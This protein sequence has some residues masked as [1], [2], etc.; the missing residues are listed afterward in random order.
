MRLL[1]GKENQDLGFSFF[2][3]QQKKA[4]GRISVDI[5]ESLTIVGGRQGNGGL[6]DPWKSYFLQC[7]DQLCSSELYNGCV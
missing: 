5:K 6:Q 4:P 1:L 3:R 7:T 2:L